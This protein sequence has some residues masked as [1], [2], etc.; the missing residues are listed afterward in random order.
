[1]VFLFFSAA[2]QVC[3]AESIDP[4]GTPGIRA[5]TADGY[6]IG[7]VAKLTHST[8][9]F[10]GYLQIME[11]AR[12]TPELRA[13]TVLFEDP[14]LALGTMG[15][16]KSDPLYRSLKRRKIRG[17]YIRIIDALNGVVLGRLTLDG[18]LGHISDKWILQNP[19][20]YAIDD[21]HPFHSHSNIGHTVRLITFR[22]GKL[23]WMDYVDEATGNELQ[24]KL[25]TS[26]TSAW[27]TIMAVPTRADLLA[28]TCTVNRGD[29]DVS[30]AL[31]SRYK[32]VEGVWHRSTRTETGCWKNR[33]DGSFPP[34]W[35]FPK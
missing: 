35:K 1:L 29:I 16:G 9:G 30:D 26:A 27:N 5:V 22:E 14:L 12:L 25:I 20:V 18:P 19:L 10:D 32:L 3:G 13:R 6:A 24:L 11:D 8:N 28:V 17:A 33:W 21:D 2:A 15:V 7:T 34:D 4:D 23:R 31:Y